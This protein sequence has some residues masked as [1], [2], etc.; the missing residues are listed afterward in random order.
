MP[1]TVPSSRRPTMFFQNHEL[2][3]LNV[4]I[5][6]NQLTK[7]P[8]NS[9]TMIAHRN[10]LLWDHAEHSSSQPTV[11]NA[12]S[13]YTGIHTRVPAAIVSGLAGSHSSVQGLPPW[14]ITTTLSMTMKPIMMTS[15]AIAARTGAT[16]TALATFESTVCASDTGQIGR[17][18][19]RENGG[20]HV[21][22]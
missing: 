20:Q 5:R 3:R 12:H 21:E 1:G 19:R 10:G 18:S 6:S 13:A 11:G 8:V 22:N 7:M 17:G 4:S 16:T 2:S 15:E 14:N 9:G